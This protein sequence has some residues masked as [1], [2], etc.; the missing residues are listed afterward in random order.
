MGLVIRGDGKIKTPQDLK[1]ARVGITTN[2]SL[3]YWLARELSRKLGFGSDGIKPV[4]L[5]A[6]PANIA[7]LKSGQIEGFIISASVGY[8]LAE[9]K[10]GAVLLHFGDYVSTFH[11]HVIFA[12]N[13]VIAEKPDVV[14]RFVAAWKET[15]DFMLANKE[16]AISIGSKTTGIPLEIAADRI[17]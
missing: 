16:E 1:G 11:T 7:S 13:K 9:K 6:L 3:S 2:G 10:E 14:R 8:M 5:G 4:P 12:T 15:V 17:R